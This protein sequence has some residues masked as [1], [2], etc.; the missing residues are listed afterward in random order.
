MKSAPFKAAASFMILYLCFGWHN[1]SYPISHVKVFFANRF[2]LPPAATATIE[3]VTDLSFS[4]LWPQIQA[5][6]YVGGV[7]Y[8]ASL[9]LKCRWMELCG[10]MG[11]V[12]LGREVF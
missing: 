2:F 10:A 1:L 5:T 12:V 3:T 9:Q 6:C 7:V 11:M 8:I 4:G